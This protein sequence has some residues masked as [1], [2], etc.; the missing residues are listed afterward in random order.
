MQRQQPTEHGL[1]GCSNIHNPKKSARQ[2]YVLRQP[3]AQCPT[4]KRMIEGF[5]LAWFSLEGGT[6][7]KG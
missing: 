5:D 2:P 1:A 4:P 7:I 3:Y 6:M